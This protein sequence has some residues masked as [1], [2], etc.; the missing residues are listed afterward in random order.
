MLVVM[1]VG[2]LF[3]LHLSAWMQPRANI[4]ARAALH[5]S[6]PMASLVTRL[7]PV[8]TFPD[9]ISLVRCRRLAPRR[10]L[11]TMYLRKGKRWR[12]S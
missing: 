3:V 8:T 10:M 5:R 9:A 6:A 2:H 11:C 7:N 12:L 1:P 4:M